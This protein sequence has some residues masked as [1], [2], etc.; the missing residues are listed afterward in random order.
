MI[1]DLR[2][3]LVREV[4]ET[5]L[6]LQKHEKVLLDFRSKQRK[7]KKERPQ[8]VMEFESFRRERQIFLEEKKCA[9]E[10]LEILSI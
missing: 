6:E 1:D 3:K 9:D 8:M 10:L 4:N 5:T 7:A 2:E